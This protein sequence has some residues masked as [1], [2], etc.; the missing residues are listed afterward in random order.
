M[1]RKCAANGFVI[2][3][4]YAEARTRIYMM[5]GTWESICV[6]KFLKSEKLC[7]IGFGKNVSQW[8]Q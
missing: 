8:K 4:N 3:E 2:P 5:C 1:T 6:I 7:D